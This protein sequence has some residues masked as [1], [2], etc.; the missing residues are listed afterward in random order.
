MCCSDTSPPLQDVVSHLLS[1]QG[2]FSSLPPSHLLNEC[3]RNKAL[4]GSGDR[5]KHELC[6]W[7]Q[8]KCPALFWHGNGLFRALSFP[9]APAGRGTHKVE[10]E[11]APATGLYRIS[12]FSLGFGEDGA[13]EEGV[14]S[15]GTARVPPGRRATSIQLYPGCPGKRS[16]SCPCHL[17]GGSG[18]VGELLTHQVSSFCRHTGGV[19][20]TSCTLIPSI[21]CRLSVPSPLVA[22]TSIP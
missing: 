9:R 2:L 3:H 8:A 11:R 4:D 6:K 10:E 7:H 21:I 14:G 17:L 19:S 22:E 18:Q 13:E 20:A 12:T 15:G 16:S 1:S 5:P